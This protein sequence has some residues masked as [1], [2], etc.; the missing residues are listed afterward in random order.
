MAANR[1][2][3]ANR[4]VSLCLQ[5]FLPGGGELSNRVWMVAWLTSV[6]MKENRDLSGEGETLTV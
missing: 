4:I 1:V 2:G 6:Y 5:L 3:A